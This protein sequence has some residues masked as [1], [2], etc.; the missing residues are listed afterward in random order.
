MHEPRPTTLG[1]CAGFGAS[2]F[3]REFDGSRKIFA[4]LDFG[5]VDLAVVVE[6]GLDP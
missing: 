6:V 1:A 4:V 3:S 5:D 2:R